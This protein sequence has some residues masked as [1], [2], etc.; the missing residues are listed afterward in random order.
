[1]SYFSILL[2]LPHICHTCIHNYTHISVYFGP[3]NTMPGTLGPWDPAS[4]IWNTWSTSWS[5]TVFTRPLEV[6]VWP[7]GDGKIWI[8]HGCLWENEMEMVGK[9]LWG[10]WYVPYK[11]IPKFINLCWGWFMIGFT[12]SN[13]RHRW[14]WNPFPTAT[15]GRRFFHLGT[16]LLI[17][18]TF[19]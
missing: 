14:C 13:F 12:T 1:M 5:T 9:N 16:G 8:S 4:R 11:G 2:G 3:T 15:R 6:T 18:S 19:L 7:K 17:L 10:L